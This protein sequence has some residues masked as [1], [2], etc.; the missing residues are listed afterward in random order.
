MWGVGW[1]E[2]GV[3]LVVAV[4]VLGPE[5]LPRMISQA[6]QWLRVIKAQAASARDDLMSAAD[7][8]SGLTDDLKRTMSDLAEFHP[9]RIAGSIISSVT[10]PIDDAVQSAK[11]AAAPPDSTT[12]PDPPKKSTPQSYDDIT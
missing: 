6:A 4:L 3:I 11:N 10:E 7:L 8:D 2:I 9:K 5:R 1:L 12:P